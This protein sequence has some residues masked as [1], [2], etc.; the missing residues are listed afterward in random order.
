MDRTLGLI[1]DRMLRMAQVRPVLFALEDAHWIDPTTL[2]LIDRIVD[3]VPEAAMLMLISHR[4]EFTAPW[5]GRPRVTQLVL[6]RLDR[7]T[8]AE[9][10]NS[11]AGADRL[12]GALRD[13]I[14]ERTDG[15]PLFVEELTL[16]VVETGGVE[17]MPSAGAD[18]PPTLKDS[19]E[20]RLDRLG[21]AKEV[22]QLGATIGRTFGY[23][24]ISRIASIERDELVELLD[25]LVTSELVQCRGELPAA[26]YT[27][28]HA[29]IQD[30]AYDSLLR[31]RR[32]SIHERIAK[33]L[34]RDFPHTVATQPD[35]LAQHYAASGQPA[36]ASKYWLRAG[37]AAFNRSAVQEAL[38]HVIAG[39]ETVGAL[40]DGPE[41]IGMEE[42]LE[43]IRA[44]ALKMSIGLA[45]AETQAAFERAYELGIKVDDSPYVFPVLFGLM[46]GDWAG[47]RSDRAHSYAEDLMSRAERSADREQL[48]VA[49]CSMGI[50]SYHRGDCNAGHQHFV[51]AEKCYDPDTDTS[52]AYRYMVEFGVMNRF[53][54]GIALFSLGYPDR[55]MKSAE[56]AVVLARR[57]QPINLVAA[58]NYGGNV[59][60]NRGD[61]ATVLE[62]SEESTAIASEF[63]F[64]QQIPFA[65]IN[66]GCAL[67]RLG[68]N[69][70]A[71][72]LIEAGMAGQGAANYVI[73][74]SRDLAHLAEALIADGKAEEALAKLNEALA[75]IAECRDHC[76]ESLALIVKGDAML[77][78][79]RATEGEQAYRHAIL[80]ADDQA[81]KSWEFRAATRLARLWH[82]LGKTTEAHDLL[83]PVYGWFTEGFDTADLKEA[84][85]LLD[86]LS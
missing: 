25:R 75:L 44:M 72:E 68:R 77:A 33:V 79:D 22:A 65:E 64:T 6:N 69:K 41:R 48:L 49:H 62:W 2:E 67:L 39:L 45:R 56:E 51:D 42:G 34:E 31:R 47:G 70:E 9:M 27:F 74:R 28:K 73:S 57:R 3:G 71:I 32:E 61:L 60:F 7:R 37:Q 8:C 81:A 10:V 29:L 52:L 35:L 1:A 85:A 55:A 19:L 40:P 15:V 12:T 20:A 46:H 58:L 43:A 26:S 23:D 80:V 36:P 86:E 13:A 16:S 50:S 83:A 4:P 59:P 14:V 78:L 24:L 17:A 30:A 54:D 21:P 82:S 84:K 63:E 5:I 18:I 76:F 11:I 38:A 53:Y 66:R